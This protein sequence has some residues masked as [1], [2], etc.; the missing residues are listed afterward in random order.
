MA[1][2]RVWLQLCLAA[3]LAVMLAPAR[4]ARAA[5]T[6]EVQSGVDP[7][8][9]AS[10]LIVSDTPFDAAGDQVDLNGTLYTLA[11]YN[12]MHHR[13]QVS[14]SQGQI[15]L[16]AAG[17]RVFDGL[18]NA[19]I[20]AKST[21]P[22]NST[23]GEITTQA[24]VTREAGTVANGYTTPSAV[25]KVIITATDTGFTLP[26]GS[27]TLL[28]RLGSA[29]LTGGGDSQG[30]F[31][32]REGFSVTGSV[33]P[34]AVISTTTAQATGAQARPGPA[35]SQSTTGVPIGGSPYSLESITTIVLDSRS[36]TSPVTAS[37]STL[38]EVTK[39]AVAP[40]PATLVMTG[41]GLAFAAGAVWRRRGKRMAVAG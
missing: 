19:V 11:A 22:G 39:A 24:S 1:T 25:G 41:I 33:D 35:S 40:E 36:T 10:Y 31:A 13:K 30:H 7:L 17:V 38:T 21:A 14:V 5:F 16:N 9:G 20:M 3:A 15:T 26:T 27:A 2:R 12:A 37:V 23:V 4:P 6:L 34:N 29:T 8:A 32:S 18:S 28:S